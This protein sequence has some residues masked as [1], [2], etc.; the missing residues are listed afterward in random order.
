M[1]CPDCKSPH[2]VCG[3]L[4]GPSCHVSVPMTNFY[5][6]E[7]FVPCCNRQVLGACIEHLQ[8]IATRENKPMGKTIFVTRELL[9]YE[10]MVD[11]G[12]RRTR[13]HGDG[14]H[15]FLDE[16]VVRP[17]DMVYI[18]LP[19]GNERFFV[20]VERDDVRQTPLPYLASNG[21]SLMKRELVDHCV[22]TR[23]IHKF[24]Y[25]EM[26]RMIRCAFGALE[27]VCCIFVHKMNGVD[28]RDGYMRI[29]KKA[30]DLIESNTG[31]LDNSGS[32]LLHDDTEAH[33]AASFKKSNDGR[34]VIQGC[35]RK[36]VI[37][38]EMKE[39]DLVVI[40]FHKRAGTASMTVR[41]CIL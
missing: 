40:T 10:V 8:S 18:C 12:D 17:G 6:V 37:Q 9:E 15:R 4:E 36:Y 22:Y 39:N 20:D 26:K 35:F 32:L 41:V 19:R 5:W 21:L 34:L 29:P 13:I 14:W 11:H 38:L 16:Y 3:D 23:G 2:A 28:I 30:V 24:E 27:D 7:A 25:S 1:E 33:V 31:V